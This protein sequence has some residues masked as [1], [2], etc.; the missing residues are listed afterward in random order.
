MDFQS[1][2]SYHFLS[3]NLFTFKLIFLVPQGAIIHC[4]NH[5]FYSKILT[6]PTPTTTSL[7]KTSLLNSL[8]FFYQSHQ[9]FYFFVCSFLSFYHIARNSSPLLLILFT[10][11]WGTSSSSLLKT[12][13]FLC[14]ITLAMTRVRI[15]KAVVF[16][17][18]MHR[19]ESWTIRKAEHRRIDAFE[20][21]CWRRLLRV[22][23]TARR[24]D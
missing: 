5:F 12:F 7:R 11:P 9:Y 15:A 6:L 13:I 17:V 22:P 10:C 19:C 1:I 23:W 4:Y 16:P 3:T 18:V 20:L 8:I 24:S 21:W 14:V 2:E